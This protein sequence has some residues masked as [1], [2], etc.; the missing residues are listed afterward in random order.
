MH[1]FSSLI[2]ILKAGNNNP[3]LREITL[4]LTLE[5]L[6][7]GCKKEYKIVKNVY[8]GLTNF[9]IDKTLVI[10]IKPGLEDNAL[11]MFHM[12]GDQVSP[13]TPPGNI[14]FKIFTKKH[15]TFIRRGNNL[16]YKHYITLEQALKGFNF[17]IKSLDNKDII[18]NVDNIVSP[19]SKMIIPN[20]G[21]PY[22][23]NPNHK[24]DLII[25][26]IHIYPETMTEAEKIA[27]RDI[28]NSTN[29]KNTSY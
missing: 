3:G 13:S 15:D 9:Q 5:E 4:E 17:S 20:E 14:I 23:D 2:F 16:I 10:D 27:L 21:M 19:N 7:Q 22:M 12:E 6:Y 26:F 24:G 1:I 29:D 18:I 28:I 8:V 11:I 25:E